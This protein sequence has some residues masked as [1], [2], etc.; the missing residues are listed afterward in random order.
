M[1]VK[2]NK[3]EYFCT[4][5]AFV[6][7]LTNVSPSSVTGLGLCFAGKAKVRLEGNLLSLNQSRPLKYYLLEF[8]S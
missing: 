6:F 5:R 7:S 3:R 2:N 4:H 1:V 8:A